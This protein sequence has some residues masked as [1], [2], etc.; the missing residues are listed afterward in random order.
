[1]NVCNLSVEYILNKNKDRQN[2]SSKTDMFIAYRRWRERFGSL[3]DDDMIQPL[4]LKTA[5]AFVEVHH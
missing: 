3:C 1:M 4:T 5:G 2:H